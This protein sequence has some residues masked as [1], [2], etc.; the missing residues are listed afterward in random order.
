ML[1]KTTILQRVGIPVI[2]DRFM[3]GSR[4]TAIREIPSACGIEINLRLLRIRL[5]Q[6]PTFAII[7]ST[8]AA[9][10]IQADNTKDGGSSGDPPPKPS[11]EP[12]SGRDNTKPKQPNPTL[13]RTYN[14]V[15]RPL[16]SKVLQG[17]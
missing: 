10:K 9:G 13:N 17:E 6:T 14:S 1:N 12:S 2:A 3:V 5:G 16:S 8:A 15:P 11:T 7:P 4:T